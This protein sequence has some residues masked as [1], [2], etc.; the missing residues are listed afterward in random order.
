MRRLQ[1]GGP[2]CNLL[3]AQWKGKRL[4]EQNILE[5]GLEIQVRLVG[6][7]TLQVGHFFLK[8]CVKYFLINI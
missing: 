1:S 2:C 5:H 3:E 4:L 8:M 7:D 6:L